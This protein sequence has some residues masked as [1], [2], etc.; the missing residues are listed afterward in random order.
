MSAVSVYI[1]SKFITDIMSTIIK[2]FVD[3]IIFIINYII[4]K[5]VI[6]R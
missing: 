5:E 6:F 2:F 4:Q 3:I 1:I